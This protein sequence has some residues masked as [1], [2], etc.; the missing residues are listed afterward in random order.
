MRWFSSAGHWLTPRQAAAAAA[1]VAFEVCR[2]EG[3]EYRSYSRA[4]AIARWPRWVRIDRK[5]HS[6]PDTSMS[7]WLNRR[8]RPTDKDWA[9]VGKRQWRCRKIIELHCGRECTCVEHGHKVDEWR[10]I[11]TS[12]WPR[13]GSRSGHSVL[14]NEVDHRRDTENWSS[15]HTRHWK[16]IPAVDRENANAVERNRR[17]AT[18]SV[19]M[20]TGRQVTVNDS[21]SVGR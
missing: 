21:D 19:A 15:R 3:F 8:H 20:R 12:R 17:R 11:A 5:E 7:Q 10:T 16:I 18:G 14:R 13:V 2:C 1:V 9:R 6:L 4:I